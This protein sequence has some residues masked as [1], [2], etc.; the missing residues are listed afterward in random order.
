MYQSIRTFLKVNSLRLTFV[1]LSATLVFMLFLTGLDRKIDP[2]TFQKQFSKQEQAQNKL[3]NH[4]ENDWLNTDKSTFFQNHFQQKNNFYVHVFRNDSLVFWNSNKFP[5]S[6]FADNRFPIN[7]IVKLQNGW[8]YSKF[9]KK[10]NLTFV[11][12]FGIKRQFPISNEQLVDYFFNPFPEFNAVITTDVNTGY[13]INDNQANSVFSIQYQTEARSN[14]TLDNLIFLD[15]LMLVLVTGFLLL[16]RLNHSSIQL[17]IYLII[18]SGLRFMLLN[19]IDVNILPESDFFDP[20]I[21]A[22]NNWIPNLGELFIWFVYLILIAPIIGIIIK[23]SSRIWFLVIWII[24]IPILMMIFPQFLREIIINSTIPI[25]LGN[26]LQLTWISAL[27]IILI[28]SLWYLLFL[29]FKIIFLKSTEFIP[30]KILITVV[31]PTLFLIVIIANEW[32]FRLHGFW[33]LW[34]FATALLAIYFVTKPQHSHSF[35]RYL[36]MILVLSLGI[37]L[38]LET[39]SKKKER[40]ER[41]LLA[42]Q[43][44]DEQDMNAEVDFIAAKEK[45]Q[46]EPYIKRLFTSTELPSF[47]ELK[48]AMEYQV[49]NGYWD[50]YD[51]DLYYFDQ[52]S[53]SKEMNGVHQT[54][55]E[56][57]IHTHGTPSEIDSNLFYVHDYTSQFNYIFKIPIE[58]N[59]VVINLYGTLRSKRIPEKIGFPRILV[60]KQTA[61]YKLLEGYSIAKYY[62][63]SLAFH[64]G[65]F[66]YP[67]RFHRFTDKNET[68]EWIKQGG[69]DHLVIQKSNR[70]A[71]IL[72]HEQYSIFS[73]LTST[74]FLMTCFGIVAFPIILF[75]VRSKKEESIKLT[76]I[77]KIQF[78]FITLILIALF[79]FSFVSSSLFSNQYSTYSKEQIQQKETSILEEIKQNEKLFLLPTSIQK[80]ELIGYQ[81][82]R[83]STVFSTDINIFNANGKLWSTSRNKI[84]NLG[85]LSEQMNPKAIEA[86]EIEEKSTFLQRENI[87]SLTYLSGYTP[88]FNHDREKIGYLNILHFNQ[89]N[90]FDEQLKQFF[91]NIINVFMLLLVLSVVIAYLASS[92]ITKPLIALRNSFAS[93]QLG[94]NNKRIHYTGSDEI[95]SLVT[96]YNQKL[97]ELEETA[98]KLAQS[99]RE[100]AWREMAKQVAHEIKNPLTPMKLSVQHLQRI[101]DP[102]DPEIEKKIAK[103]TQSLVDQIDALTAIANEFSNFAKL[104]KPNFVSLNLVDLCQSAIAFF[105]NNGETEITF[106]QHPSEP[107]YIWADK[108]LMLRVLNNLITNGIQAVEHN[109]K[110]TIDLSLQQTPT[111]T[112]LFVKDN[113]KGISPDQLETIFEPY[114]T[115]KSTGTGLGLAMVKQ[116]IE[117]HNGRIEVE[118]TS[119]AG[120]TFKVEIPLSNTAIY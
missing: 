14:Q 41:V 42:N 22:I 79:G 29:F 119:S 115:T 104:P 68:Q 48:E 95:G 107:I 25:H 120:T 110:A 52:D 112:I 91:V 114:F 98:R 15:I 23:N 61:V 94:K 18:I 44:V 102:S 64:H 47:S 26:I 50:R 75:M 33:I 40:E 6:N 97:D 108:D 71:I 12:S 17:G 54:Q 116:I 89:Q 65:E 76:L 67:T 57:L 81:L 11:V 105:D 20:S 66:N 113:G 77:S 16:K 13:A 90:V 4:I 55:L 84:Y 43:L 62:N 9:K 70:D 8:Y 83:W 7:G 73:Y 93:M 1:V 92:W 106:S 80:N 74:A 103:T 38:N 2:Q 72:S 78:S 117:L 46:K 58:K 10:D 32:I 19:K 111:H 87:G 31:L 86:L 100:S 36:V 60:S 3:L 69:Y 99:E 96:E 21:L 101:F 5:I 118:E 59:G 85:L 56:E 51:V 30:H 53:V 34:M 63:G 27:L 109:A 39:E 35:N 82:R 37:T 24:S 88:I 49:F 45:L 28:G